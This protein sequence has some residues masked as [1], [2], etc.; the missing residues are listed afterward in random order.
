MKLLERLDRI[1][2]PIAIPNLT[3]VLIAGQALM[4]LGG[5]GNKETLSRMTLV[6]DNVI[7]GEVWR[8]GDVLVRAGLA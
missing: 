8:P 4:F 2:R 3:L 1:V 7:E 6:W 5:K